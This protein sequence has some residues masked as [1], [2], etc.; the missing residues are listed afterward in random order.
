MT[1]TAEPRRENPYF[2]WGG[3]YAPRILAVT[4]IVAIA[5]DLA[6]SPGFMTWPVA[7]VFTAGT[8]AFILDKMYH[9]PRLCERCIT[10]SPLDPQAAVDRWRQ[11][12][13]WEHGRRV[14]ILLLLA[15]VAWFFTAGFRGAHPGALYGAIDAVALLVLASSY[16]A[17]YVHRRLYP[18][19]PWCHWDDGG[20]RELV[21][22]PDPEDHGVKP[23]PS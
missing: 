8:A 23:V 11:A 6:G 16:V 20:P 5:S 17:M 15:C 2:M 10:A 22:D 7:V 9:E 19:C 21:P 12:L 1:T 14:K 4:V 18:W 13:R 3:H